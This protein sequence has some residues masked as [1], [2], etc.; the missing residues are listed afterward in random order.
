MQLCFTL[1]DVLSPQSITEP[2]SVR[3]IVFWRETSR[4]AGFTSYS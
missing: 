1:Y 3:Q 4:F 2:K